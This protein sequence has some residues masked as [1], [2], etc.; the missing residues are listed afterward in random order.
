MSTRDDPLLQI[1]E[2]PVQGTG[3]VVSQ[4]RADGL[5][6]VESGRGVF[7]LR[8]AASCLLAPEVGDRIWFCGDLTGG[9]YATAVL[10]RGSDANSRVCL[11][12]GSR[13]EVEQGALI[14]RADTLRLESRTLAA[15]TGEA[16]LAAKKLTGVGQEAVL[17][18]TKI[19]V[20]GELLESFAER[21]IQFARWSQRTVDGPDQVRSR[22][23]DYRAEQTMQLS[24]QNFIAD[25]SNLVKMDGEQIHLG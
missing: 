3:I 21:L 7:A 20:I 24:A 4:S 14:L 13:I 10:E 9:L 25:A 22:Q 8:R 17:S 2:Q 11:P 5:Y 19:K 1:C 16:V 23:I 18:F 6:T 12:A 15:H